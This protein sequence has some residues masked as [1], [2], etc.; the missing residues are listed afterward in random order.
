MSIWDAVFDENH[1]TI[2]CQNYQHNEPYTLPIDEIIH[3]D[4]TNHKMS[5]FK[6]GK[7]FLAL[8]TNL[9]F[10]PFFGQFIQF[11]NFVRSRQIGLSL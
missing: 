4:V 2:R 5:H 1:K 9:L 11:A 8:L 6:N 3:P 10:Q 7:L